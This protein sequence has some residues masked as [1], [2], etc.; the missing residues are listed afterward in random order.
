MKIARSIDE[1]LIRSKE[2]GGSNLDGLA[3]PGRRRAGCYAVRT[4]VRDGKDGEEAGL[5]QRY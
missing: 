5:L 1:A 3:A 2:A 4:C